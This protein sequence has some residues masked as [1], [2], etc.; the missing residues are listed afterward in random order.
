MHG[1]HASKAFDRT[2]PI[3]LTEQFEWKSNVAKLCS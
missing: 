3:Y 2:L 1:G